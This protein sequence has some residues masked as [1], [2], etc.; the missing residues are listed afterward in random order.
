[1]QGKGL[2][3]A[4]CPRRRVSISPN[5]RFPAPGPAES[6]ELS[7]STTS[8]TTKEEEACGRRRTET[9]ETPGSS[10]RGDS[11][12][13][14]RKAPGR[15]SPPPPVWPMPSR[16]AREPEDRRRAELSW[17]T[18]FTPFIGEARKRGHIE[19]KRTPGTRPACRSGGRHG[20]KP[21]D[22][23][24]VP[25][26]GRPGGRSGGAAKAPGTTPLERRTHSQA[27]D[28][29]RSSPSPSR[30]MNC[31]TRPRRSMSSSRSASTR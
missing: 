14:M 7:R 13:S 31:R 22:R 28:H 4:R 20:L 3:P 12:C 21:E 29:W 27:A 16:Q 11:R 2:Q 24:R 30:R 5:R 6:N 10:P 25:P 23:R 9:A 8:T 17:D 1:M 15:P 18:S 26:R 19:M